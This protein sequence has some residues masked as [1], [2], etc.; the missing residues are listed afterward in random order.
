MQTRTK[1]LAAFLALSLPLAA[2][3]QEAAKPAPPPEAKTTVTVYGTINANLHYSK[4]DGETS[5]TDV[6]GRWAVSLDSSNIGFRGTL[7]ASPELGATFQCE[8][9]ANVDGIALASLCNRN[10]RVGITGKSWGTLWYGNWDT[11]VKAGAYGTKADDPF[12]N[13]DVFGHQNIMGSPG[14]GYRSSAWLT[15][16][17]SATTAGGF[18]HGF[19]IRANNSVG[20]HSPKFGNMLSVKL[21]YSVNELAPADTSEI[22]QGL[23]SGVLNLDYG[24]LSAFFSYERHEDAMALPAIVQ[25]PATNP[26]TISTTDWIW[27]A[28]A[29]YEFKWAAGATTPVFWFEQLTLGQ[30]DAPIGGFTEA[31]RWAWMAGLKHRYQNHEVRFRYSTADDGECSVNGGTCETVDAGAT[32]AGEPLIENV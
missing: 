18:I 30:D 31:K 7:E 1:L 16:N 13:T 10:S 17:P 4:A 20:Y 6:D 5:A 12:G 11:P 25:D 3:A 19:D 24:P 8:T 2:L 26:V 9:A 23:L 32:T 27:R 22:S 21:Q 15:G 14:F 28:G 29:G